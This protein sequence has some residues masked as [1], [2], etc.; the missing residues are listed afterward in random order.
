MSTEPPEDEAT[1]Y[2]HEAGICLQA[3]DDKQTRA[4]LAISIRLVSELATSVFH[5][6][7]QLQQVKAAVLEAGE[8]ASR[9]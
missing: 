2:V 3:T 9:T 4:L 7:D 6:R 8:K 5:L 1:Y